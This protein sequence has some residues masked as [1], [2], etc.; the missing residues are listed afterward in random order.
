MYFKLKCFI[1]GI[2][3]KFVEMNPNNVP[4]KNS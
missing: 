1:Y 3:F 2:Y 4:R